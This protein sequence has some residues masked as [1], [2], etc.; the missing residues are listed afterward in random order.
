MN[1]TPFGNTD[2]M[3]ASLA[4]ALSNKKADT[5]KKMS[6]PKGKRYAKHGGSKH[7]LTSNM[8]TDLS[9]WEERAKRFKAK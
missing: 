3:R 1:A 8:S 5:A 7:R 6:S 4:K 9:A 2:A